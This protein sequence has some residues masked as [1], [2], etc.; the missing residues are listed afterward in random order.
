M[1]LFLELDKQITDPSRDVDLTGLEKEGVALQGGGFFGVGCFFRVCGFFPP[2]VS[3]T[4]FFQAFWKEGWLCILK[5]TNK[6]LTIIQR[7]V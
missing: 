5:K 3:L 2:E 6:N 4:V 1:V 7:L